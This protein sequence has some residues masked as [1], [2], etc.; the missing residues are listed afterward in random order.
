MK[1]MNYDQ[2]Q[3]Y[4]LSSTLSECLSEDHLCFTVSD[5]VDNL[6]FS[7]IEEDYKEEDY[8][9][10]HPRMMF[11]VLFYSYTQGAH[12][13][14]K[15]ENKTREDIVFRYLTANNHLDQGAINLFRK[16]H[17]KELPLLFPRSLPP[18]KVWVWQA[19]PTFL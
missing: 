15:L 14:R 11:K 3:S 2:K 17:L 18:F 13:S 16:N 4:L 12:S 10:H 9:A 1:F 7:K 8:P 6:D 19:F 5:I